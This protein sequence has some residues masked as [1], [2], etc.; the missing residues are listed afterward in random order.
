MSMKDFSK[1]AFGFVT[2]TSLLF[3]CGPGLKIAGT[4]E[5]E[6]PPILPAAPKY[7]KRST[8]AFNV[9]G[10][11]ADADLAC[12]TDFGAGYKALV[13]HSTSRFAPSTDWPLRAYQEYKRDDDVTIGT[14]TSGAIFAFPLDNDLVTG[15]G[16]SFA[17]GLNSDFTVGDNCDDWTDATLGG[18]FDYDSGVPDSSATS[19]I[20][21]NP[22]PG[23]MGCNS[24]STRPVLCVEQ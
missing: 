4:N 23:G 1:Q 13:G 9:D 12:S 14:T 22:G 21:Q 15:G 17:T 19:A 16:A 2:L 3:S 24:V 18:G 20:D 7:I 6:E 11:L 5:P 8:T 10:G